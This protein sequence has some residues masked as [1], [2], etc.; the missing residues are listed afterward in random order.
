MGARLREE[1]QDLGLEIEQLEELRAVELDRVV[2]VLPPEGPSGQ[3]VVELDAVAVVGL[4]SLSRVSRRSW[5]LTLDSR[6]CRP[7][8]WMIGE[9]LLDTLRSRSPRRCRPA[10]PRS[11][12]RGACAGRPGARGPPRCSSCCCSRTPSR[13]MLKPEVELPLEEP[14][15]LEGDHGL[16]GELAQLEADPEL[17][18]VPLEE[19]PGV[20]EVEIGLRDLGED[21]R[22]LQRAVAHA[23]GQAARSALLD[24]DLQVP[25]ARDVGVLGSS[26]RR[27]RTACSRGAAC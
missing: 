20:E 13:K 12:R 23:E 2:V 26:P 7:A 15:L 24:G 22:P 3:P 1:G 9:A 8:R 19:G 21:G 17:F 10:A 6:C 5:R 11:A 16:A 25:A 4:I 14:G 18:A 27:R